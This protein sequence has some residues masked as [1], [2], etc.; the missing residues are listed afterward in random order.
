MTFK[1]MLV[2]KTNQQLIIQSLF[3]SAFMLFN[4]VLFA[5]LTV[6]PDRASTRYELGES[7]NFKVSGATSSTV[8]YQI[9]HTIIDTF[10][11]FGSGT[12]PVVNG[13]ATIPFTA[14]ENGFVICL[15]KHNMDTVYAGASFS[16]EKLMPLEEEPADFDAFWAAQKAA[17]RAVPLD[18]NVTYIRTSNYGFGN[19]SNV[20]K[21]DVAIINGRRAYGYMVVPI[22]IHAPY[23][24]II[25]MPS[26]GHVANLVTDN[27][28]LA[29]RSGAI[30]IFLSPHNDPPT[31]T[32]SS[33][34]YLTDGLDAPG[35]Y[36]IRYALLGAVKVIDYLQT[37][38]DFNGQVGA[39]GI[40]QGGGLVALAAGIDNRIS[41]LAEAYSGFSNQIGL[42]YSQPSAFPFFFHTA[43][44]PTLSRETIINT[45]K[46]YDPIYALRRFKGVSWNA[47]SHKDHV[48]PPQ[49]VMTAFNQIK[50]QKI[51]EFLFD[52]IHEEGPE[53]F[54]NSDPQLSAYAFFRRYFP[55]S[56]VAPWPYNPTTK[57][58]VI[59]AGKDTTILTGTTLNLV[60]FIGMND[61]ALANLPVKW[62]KVEG[63]GTV[64]FSNQTGRNTTASFSQNGT[65]R[66]RFRA[67][68]TTSIASRRYFTIS[69]DIVV[70]VS[71]SIPIELMRFSGIIKDKSNEL[72]WQ[73]ASEINNKGF[74]IER[75]NDANRWQTLGFVKGNG[76][77]SQI[78]TYNFT[79]EGPLS[80]SYYRLRQI[81]FNGDFK[82]SNVIS[83]NRNA[84][85]EVQIFPNPASELLTMRME[86]GEGSEIKIYDILGKTMLIEKAFGKETTVNI[87]TLAKG[88]YFVEIKNGQFITTK[89]FIK[90]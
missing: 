16:P 72:T 47:I 63:L 58:Y 15:V 71:A 52:K 83:L 12:V 27:S 41:L 31:V 65:Y 75:S 50:G 87:S 26:F 38:S 6:K 40:S 76:N 10:R 17:V 39:L 78:N 19:L 81:D 20:F 77:S 35:N 62:E 51:I 11:L 88:N 5:Q 33:A 37:R 24:A 42:K 9:K 32:S 3:L 44:T 73:T 69:N 29:E 70:K 86:N 61:T 84:K 68:D 59:D 1:R 55:K 57:G 14:T 13:E 36:Y 66:L 74:D 22:S 85:N 45:T 4:N 80:I 82:Y 23:P 30:S 60:G 34:D 8:T 2:F 64:T 28:S 21:F 43:Y 79:D 54:Y 25:T 56:R 46:Y 49:A 67:L 18:M 53:E 48:C 89:K 90:N 7:M